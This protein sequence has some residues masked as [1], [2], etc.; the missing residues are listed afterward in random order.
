MVLVFIFFLEVIKNRLQL[1][2]LIFTEKAATSA[3]VNPI[4]AILLGWY[5]LDKEITFQM[6][7][8]DIGIHKLECNLQ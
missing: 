4:I 3:Y 6:G 7:I 8:A 2:D 1:K 5:V